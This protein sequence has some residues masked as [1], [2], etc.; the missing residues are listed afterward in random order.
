MRGTARTIFMVRY[1]HPDPLPL[2]RGISYGPPLHRGSTS[3]YLPKEFSNRF[4]HG[5]HLRILQRR[6][7]RQA[8]H[9]SAQPVCI[10][11]LRRLELR[12]RLLPRQRDRIVN[13]RWNSRR[14][15]MALQRFPMRRGH[16][17]KMIV[18]VP[19]LRLQADRQFR[20]VPPIYRRNLAPAPVP[21]IQP[22]QFDIQNRCMNL[23]QPAVFSGDFR[24]VVVPLPIVSEHSR[25]FGNLRVRR[26]EHS[27][28]A[29]CPEIL[30]G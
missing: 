14:R 9:L 22:I 30:R 13:K 20:Q 18:A 25:A 7:N 27:G 15:Q 17:K 28:I 12:K 21:R 3:R 26:D 16:D 1:P 10:R 23:I 11:A 24:D 4:D 6:V 8:Q 2:G 29:V 5:L 19:G